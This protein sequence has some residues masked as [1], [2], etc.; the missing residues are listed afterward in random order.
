MNA[1]SPAHPQTQTPGFPGVSFGRSAD[2]MPVALVG[3]T[4]FAMAM[5]RD[6]RHYLVTAWRLSRAMDE[7]TRADFY[8]EVL[9]EKG[10]GGCLQSFKEIAQR[11]AAADE[12]C[13]N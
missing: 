1:P 7:W 3:D 4:A 8:G 11:K 2:G 10:A 9:D 12:E 5:A 13:D 6:D